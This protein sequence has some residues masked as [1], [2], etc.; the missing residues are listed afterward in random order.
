MRGEKQVE[1][2]T[3]RQICGE[4]QRNGD[5]ETQRHRECQRYKERHRNRDTEW[6][7]KRLERRETVTETK[8]TGRQRK[9]WGRGW[10]GAEVRNGKL[11]GE[12][13]G[14]ETRAKRQRRQLEGEKERGGDRRRKR[15]RRIQ[16]IRNGEKGMG[17]EEGKPLLQL[18]LE[19]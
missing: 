4:R 16:R 14:Q 9:S 15:K 12:R 11:E 3:E 19:T 18:S 5:R 7:E 13:L 10:G 2:E 1:I 8:N 17:K 6:E